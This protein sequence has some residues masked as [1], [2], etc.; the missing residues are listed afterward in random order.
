MKKYQPFRVLGDE[1]KDMFPNLDSCRCPSELSHER[2]CSA[3]V[4]SR[5]GTLLH[6]IGRDYGELGNTEIKE[7]QELYM[8]Q[9]VLSGEIAC[10]IMIE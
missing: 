10:S 3:L 8:Y 9:G 5:H 7:Y 2:P 1:A 6:A 4:I